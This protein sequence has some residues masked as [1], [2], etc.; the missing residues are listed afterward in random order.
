VAKVIK[1]IFADEGNQLKSYRWI[2]R[3]GV[4]IGRS[5]SSGSG[6]GK[7]IERRVRGW[8]HDPKKKGHI[9]L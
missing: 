2:G 4:F 6:V 7:K 8:I 5:Q 9:V 1:G 3:E